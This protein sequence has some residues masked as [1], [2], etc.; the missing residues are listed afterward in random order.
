[1]PSDPYL[2]KLVDMMDAIIA[3]WVQ[4]FH[5]LK[6]YVSN[7]KIFDSVRYFFKNDTELLEFAGKIWFT[8]FSTFD[9]IISFSQL[10]GILRE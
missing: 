7:D 2:L 8:C 3:L 10:I 5:T 1:M 6:L 9:Y 4:T